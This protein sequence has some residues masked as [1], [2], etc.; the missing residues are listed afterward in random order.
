MIGS[1]T[2][3]MPA[4]PSR[5][6]LVAAVLSVTLIF[7]FP[8]AQGQ[9]TASTVRQVPPATG[10]EPAAGTEDAGQPRP[11]TGAPLSILPALGAPGPYL[12]A[13]PADRISAAVSDVPADIAINDEFGGGE[14]DSPSAEGQ[15]GI[16]VD[17]LTAIDPSAVGLLGDDD[18]GFGVDMWSGT[19]RSVV[20]SL[21]PRL[22]V[23]GKSPVLRSLRRRLLLTSA[24]VPE[25]RASGPGLLGLRLDKL[26]AS[27]DLSGLVGLLERVSGIAGDA[28]VSRARADALLLV[29][30]LAGA[31]GEARAAVRISQEAYWLKVTAFCRVLEGDAA[32]ASLAVELLLEEGEDDVVFFALM[33]RLLAGNIG[34]D[35][36]PLEIGELITLTPLGLGMF[37]AA[38][39]SVPLGAIVNAPPLILRA[40]ATTPATSINTRL[41]AADAALGLGAID[42]ELLGQIF[43][44]LDFTDG[45][46]DN[47]LVIANADLG[48][49]AD[50]LLHQMVLERTDPLEQ[51]ELLGAAWRL[52]RRNGNYAIIARVNLSAARAI[53]P[54]PALVASAADI[55][56]AL[57]LAGD[58]ERVFGWYAVARAKAADGDL[59][60]TRAL[61]DMWPLLQITDPRHTLPWSEQILDLWW[62]GQTALPPPERVARGRLLFALLEAMGQPVP[63][64]FWSRLYPGPL[65]DAAPAP[66]MAIW[67]GMV[68]AA[69]AGR[70]GETVLMVLLAVGDE[71]VSRASPTVLGSAVASLRSVGLEREARALALEAA[72]ARGL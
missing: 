5:R 61:L 44:A 56:R 27:G 47:A 48:A 23:S 37:R 53:E 66:N 6:V 31:C 49:K 2:N 41:Q 46:R 63:D 28:A 58:L 8:A 17:S 18:G 35:A 39:Q 65:I 71:G 50:A 14:I 52:A 57:L 4:R 40:I 60:A 55:S 51:S 24:A 22:P 32:G 1:P 13:R 3:P 19:K 45:E 36:A 12:A 54:S 62:Q 68:T 30:D 70:V 38:R 26:A 72:L 34:D 7:V 69:K 10:P 42:A 25:G 59:D 67:R 20:E 9:E 43:A 21:L 64:S 29:G 33:N 11:A 15:A 16:S